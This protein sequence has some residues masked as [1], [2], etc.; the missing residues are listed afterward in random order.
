M[1]VLIYV[2]DIL[3]TSSKHATVSELLENLHIEF[4]V[5]DLGKL[6]FFLSIEVIP[7]RRGVLL[8]QHCYILG[9]LKRTKM[10][11]AKPATSQWPYPRISQ[12]LKAVCF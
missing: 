1:L 6:N 2:D 7:C 3:I 5:K 12:L 9:I 8:S 10:S 11:K 4:V